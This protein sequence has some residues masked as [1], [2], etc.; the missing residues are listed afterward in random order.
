MAPGR[1]TVYE[2][3]DEGIAAALAAGM[4]VIDVRSH[5]GR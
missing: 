3:S 5:T 2:D 1:C 4:T